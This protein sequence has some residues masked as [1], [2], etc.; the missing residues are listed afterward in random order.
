MATTV[1]DLV[2]KLSLDSSE[3]DSGMDDAESK[4]SSFGDK[5]KSGLGSA[6]KVGAGAVA[7]LGSAAIA[8]GTAIVKGT[9]DTAAYGDNIDKMSQKMGLSAQA[10]QEWD[11]IMQHSGTSI[12]AMKRGMTTLSKAVEDGDESF[13][14]LG[15]SVD[16]LKNMS[17]EDIFA[18]TIKA[19]QNM[20]SGTERTV[21]AQKLLGGS[22]KEL[23]ALLNTSAEDTEKMR[24]KVHELG[25]VLSDEAVKNA[26]AFQ[27]SL[28]D[29]QTAIGSIGRGLTAEFLPSLTQVMDGI[30]ALFTG[31]RGG[32]NMISKGLFDMVAKIGEA[33]PK[34]IET[35]TQLVNSV[36]ETIVQNLPQI[37]TA[38]IQI[39]TNL[40]TGITQ[41]LPNIL[42]TA[43]QLIV[44]LVT[45]IAQALP[46]LVP[47]AVDMI[48]TIVDTL[49]ENLPQIIDA[50]LQLITALTEG[51]IDAL[52]V[53]IER[54][55]EII[56]AIV[57]T[58]VE[59]FPKIVEAAFKLIVVFATALIDNIPEIVN[60][61]L[62]I[63]EKINAKFQ[64]IAGQALSWGADLISNFVS[65]IKN[66]FG[67]IKSAMSGLANVVKSHI[68]FSEPDVGPLSDF[69]TYAPDMMKQFAKGIDENLPLVED[70]MNRM[71]NMVRGNM[72]FSTE[73][74]NRGATYNG[75]ITINVYGAQGQ[76]EQQLVDILMDEITRRTGRTKA[77]WA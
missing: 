73:G 38:G 34:M 37:I 71:G 8:A 74:V 62:K 19:L 7:A 30:S 6:A 11:A 13:A 61:I 22:S 43:V 41:T 48:L 27:D 16:E 40:V 26:A 76:S 55:P 53:L 21:L 35:A 44:A 1:F 72:Q 66:G 36:S 32:I 58:L 17:Q 39:V 68:H 67:K 10:Y 65:G 42:A 33:I 18:A 63:R 70:S 77:V 12:D 25:G 75:G 15:L 56:L 47:A 69:H 57:D 2:A 3:F 4:S 46:Q 64:E 28:Q 49:I 51:L 59:N 20:E 29:M 31:D 14:K 52:P 23:G 45:G 50:A 60:A 5:L 54:A 24:Q 9:A